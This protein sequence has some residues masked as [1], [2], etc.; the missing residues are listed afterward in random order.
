MK[1]YNVNT[2]RTSHYPSDPLLL[3]LATIHGIYIIDEAD[4]ETHGCQVGTMLN[5]N[6]ISNDSKWERHYL[7]RAIH[8]YE[9]DKNNTCIIMWSLGNEAG[10]YQKEIFFTNPL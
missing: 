4:L 2:I 7:D 1:E 10:G 8:L 6:L 9:R 3:D 5:F